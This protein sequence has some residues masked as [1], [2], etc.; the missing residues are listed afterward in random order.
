ADNGKGCCPKGSVSQNDDGQMM[1]TF[2]TLFIFK[3]HNFQKGA[4]LQPTSIAK[5]PVLQQ[6][7]APRPSPKQ[8]A[9]LPYSQEPVAPLAA[10]KSVPQPSTPEPATPLASQHSVPQPISQQPAPGPSTPEPATPLAS[11]HSVPQPISQQPAPGPSTQERAAPYASQPSFINFNN[12]CS[13]Q[14]SN[15]DHWQKKFQWQ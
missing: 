11:Q 12:L 10:Q 4:H 7:P 1:M 6:Q 5:E 9:I 14:L 15:T 8:P 2:N 13:S 3:G